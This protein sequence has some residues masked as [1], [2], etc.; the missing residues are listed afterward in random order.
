MT[1][2]PPTQLKIGAVVGGLGQSAQNFWSWDRHQVGFRNGS[3]SHFCSHCVVHCLKSVLFLFTSCRPFFGWG[4]SIGFRRSFCWVDLVSLLD[5][6]VGLHCCL[7]CRFRG[8][9]Q[10][11]EIQEADR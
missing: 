9:G 11:I 10:F 8:R 2:D 3:Q 5:S 6:P 1:M 7:V 4:G